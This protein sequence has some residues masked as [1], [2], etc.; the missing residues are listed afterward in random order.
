M[1]GVPDQIPGPLGD[2]RVTELGMPK[3]SGVVGALYLVLARWQGRPAL[4][5][6]T[7]LDRPNSTSRLR[8]IADIP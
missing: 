4:Q 3:M 7:L 8:F 5:P 2:Q 1:F 6:V